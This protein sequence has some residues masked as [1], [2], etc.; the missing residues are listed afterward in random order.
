S[1]LFDGHPRHACAR[2]APSFTQTYTGPAASFAGSRF[3]K[4][5]EATE[6]PAARPPV[7]KLDAQP[8]AGVSPAAVDG[9]PA[10]CPAP[11]VVHDDPRLQEYNRIL[12]RY[13]QYGRFM[14]G[15]VI[16]VTMNQSK[17][18]GHGN[19]PCPACFPLC[20]SCNLLFGQGTFRV[21]N[22]G[23]KMPPCERVLRRG[24]AG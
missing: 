11:R 10:K 24:I 13:V 22:S 5:R 3:N 21:T 19:L 23:K 17:Q 4:T 8:A 6:V 18:E 12:R 7:P 20:C 2:R 1:R 9:R 15:V 14:A 16:T